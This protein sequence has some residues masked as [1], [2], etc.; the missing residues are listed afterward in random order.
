MHVYMYDTSCAAADPET[1]LRDVHGF[2][3]GDEN[4]A[5]LP[6]VPVTA[7]ITVVS[8]RRKLRHRPL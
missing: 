2:K 8:L 3:P 4:Y 1:T 6:E 7:V 5:F